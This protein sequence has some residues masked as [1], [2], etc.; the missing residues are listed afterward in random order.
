[1]MKSRF[2]YAFYPRVWSVLERA[3]LERASQLWGG[4]FALAF[5]LISGAL[6]INVSCVIN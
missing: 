3:G 5:I 4:L 6:N 1:M 2:Y